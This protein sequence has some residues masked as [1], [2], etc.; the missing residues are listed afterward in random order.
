MF[1]KISVVLLGLLALSTVYHQIQKKIEVNK[2]PAPG[3]MIRVGDG[4]M[5]IYGKGEGSPAILFTCGNGMGFTLGNYYPVFSA[6][7]KK[8]RVVIYDRFGYG[9]SDSTSRPRTMKQINEDLYELLDKSPETG[10]F[11]L[12]GHSLGATEVV[13]FA[14]RYPELVVGVVTLDGT[15]PTF[16]RNRKSLHAQ[17]TV[18]AAIARLLSAT[19][20]LRILTNINLLSTAGA[21]SPK[22]IV[23]IT[24]M[25]TYNRVYSHEAVEEVK[26]LINNDQEQST[27]GDIPVLILTADNL[28]MK[29]KQAEIYQ[30]FVN[31][32][33][34]LLTLSSKSRQKIIEN[35]DHF[36]PIKKP[37]IVIE[38]LLNF[39]DTL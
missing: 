27:L 3:E 36:F 25:M 6:L 14:Q 17:N 5:H 8:T 35:A 23:K 28:K 1:F 39:L 18:A 29:K 30:Y 32:Q 37:D 7:A 11:I 34:E 31:S 24:N 20:L 26:A 2:N 10:P 22:E 12:V 4:R 38:E 9:W 15:S 21:S 13:E 16:Y 33:K 19:G